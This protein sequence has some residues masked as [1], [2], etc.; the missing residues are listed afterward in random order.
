MTYVKFSRIFYLS[1]MPYRRR[2]RRGG[3]SRREREQLAFRTGRR[4]PSGKGKPFKPTSKTYTCVTAEQIK[5]S[6]T[7]AGD[8]ACFDLTNYNQPAQLVSSTTFTGGDTE[9][10][11]SGHTDA[12]DATGVAAYNSVLVLSAHYKFDVRFIGTSATDKDFIF[13]YKFGNQSSAAM[14]L[15]AGATTV[16]LWNDMRQTRGWVWKQFSATESGGSSY[17]SQ[18]TVRVNV[19]NVPKLVLAMNA[20]TQD[21]IGIE[22]LKHT[23]DDLAATDTAAV[24]SFLHIAVFTIDGTALS[25]TP[26]PDISIDVT[27]YKK[28]RLYMPIN[29]TEMIDEIDLGTG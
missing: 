7:T 11:P 16:K 3:M 9:R 4:A 26:N 10:H 28:V 23:I 24:R 6:A 22:N 27:V 29:T 14:V 2:R 1:K 20:N 8:T 21:E 12:I 18:A 15:T 19:P 25:V 13:A 17:P 5:T